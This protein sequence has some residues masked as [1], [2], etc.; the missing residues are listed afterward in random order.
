MQCSEA[1]QLTHGLLWRLE[2]SGIPGASRPLHAREVFSV[3]GTAAGVRPAA[4]VAR[5][6]R[7][8]RGC[9]R[10]VDC[11]VSCASSAPLFI[12][13]CPPCECLPPYFIRQTALSSRV[14]RRKFSKNFVTS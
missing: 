12:D 4:F 13:L 1:S 8:M 10:A 3:H 5:R 11:V 2:G 6:G 9:S 7:G 14:T